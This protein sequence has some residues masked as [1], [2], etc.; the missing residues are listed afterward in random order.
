M[1][2]S[3]ALKRLTQRFPNKRVFI[4]G[5]TSGLGEALA[6]EFASAGWRVAVTGR[7]T[8]KA[9]GAAGK[10]DPM[11]ARA[12]ADVASS[13]YSSEDI[14]RH[15]I[16]SIAKGELYSLPMRETRLGWLPLRLIPETGRAM[17][18]WMYRK[19]LWKFAPVVD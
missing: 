17:V 19:Q 16:I 3:R 11:Q 5:A 14:A 18:A 15:T 4:T 12:K 10:N 9:A 1:D 2:I 8:E 6:I 13:A 7:S